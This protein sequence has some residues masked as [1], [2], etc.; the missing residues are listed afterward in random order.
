MSHLVAMK[1]CLDLLNK[2]AAPLNFAAGDPGRRLPLIRD[3]EGT[4]KQLAVSLDSEMTRLFTAAGKGNGE[5]GE[6]LFL[7]E[8]TGLFKGFDQ[9]PLARK[10]QSIIEALRLLRQIA[11][12]IVPALPAGPRDGEKDADH[13][14]SSGA[15]RDHVFLCQEKLAQPTTAVR[16]V[17]PKTARLLERKGIN[18]VGDL[19]YFLPRRYEDRRFPAQIAQLHPGARET[20]AGR[21]SQAE[22]KYYGKRPVF[23]VTIEDETGRLKA[24]WFRG[25]PAYL[26]QVFKKGCQVVL[27]GATGQFQQQREMIHPDFE[28]LDDAGDNLLHY[29]RIVPIYSET[30]GLYQKNI[31]RITKQAVDDYLT[32]LSSP[33]PEGICLRHELIDNQE[34]LRQVHFP[35][36]DHNPEDYND[37][38]SA[39][40]RR[41]IFDDFFFFQLGM[42]L[43]RKGQVLEKGIAFRTGGQAVAKFYELLPFLLTGAQRRV[44]AEIERDMARPGPMNRLLQGDVGC[45]KTV[46]AMAAMITACDNGFQA[47]LMAPTEILAEQHYSAIKPW[48]DALGLKSVLLTGNRSAAEKAILLKQIREGEA[49]LVIGTHALIQ[50]EVA[51][52]GLGLAV[53]DE[54]HRFGV[55]QRAALREKGGHPDLLVMTATPIPRTLAMTVY[56][57]LDVSV[58]DEL[59]PGHRPVPAA[60]FHERGRSKVYAMV[61]REIKKGNQVFIVYPLVEESEHLD[62]KDAVG[63]AQHL[64]KEVFPEYRVGLLHGKMKRVEKE[65]AMAAFSKRELDILVATTVIEVGIDIPAASLMVIEHA[66]RFGLSQLHQLR[67]RVGRGEALSSCI[68]LTPG[69]ASAEAGR[70]L[71]IMENTTDGFLIAEEDLQLRGP[72]EFMGTRQSGLPDFRVADIIRD[73]RLL[74]EA[75]DCAFALV[76]DDPGLQKPEHRLLKEV[77][78][79]RWAGSLELSRTS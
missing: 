25:N 58:I 28:M 47:A 71:A 44:I 7:S 75:K 19:L 56:G 4:M 38:R 43:R 16:G 48:A 15:A 18:T 31:R 17:G 64:Q 26:R 53:I 8:L 60:V 46:V 50:G 14:S 9:F 11:D 36:Q 78:K 61:R 74:Q 5:P 27:T 57:D 6:R 41:L 72:G 68:L 33:I 52:A 20:V 1:I 45:G 79:Q 23:E 66:E 13:G 54:Q 3:L 40:H 67:G 76:E 73:G 51:F 70:R 2:I 10:E 32:Y 59:P 55:V 29:R 49:R 35:A 30:E 34:A 69:P 22:I 63:M 42:A 65:E 12:L 77:L 62:M 39:A 24:K 21:V 37:R